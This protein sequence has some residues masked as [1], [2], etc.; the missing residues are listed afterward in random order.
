MQ[1]VEVRCGEQQ[2]AECEA[3]LVA[4]VSMVHLRCS[5]AA[6]QRCSGAAVLGGGGVEGAPRPRPPWRPLQGAQ[7]A[8]RP[9]SGRGL[10]VRVGARVRGRV[11]VRER[12]E[13]RGGR[14]QRR[15]RL[16]TSSLVS[17]S[18]HGGAAGAPRAVSPET[19]SVSSSVAVHAAAAPSHATATA[20]ASARPVAA[21][22]GRAAPRR[23]RIDGAMTCS[24]RSRATSST[25]LGLR[26]GLGL[27]LGL[28]LGL[29]LGSE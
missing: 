12:V 10:D 21:L 1:L 23:L 25:W 28:G 16:S 24:S 14:G 20:C 6:V 29:R 2:R 18:P 8:P 7:A 19:L 26:L 22:H 5:G 4:D 27:E 17:G 15:G 11:E 9:A 13:V 3:R